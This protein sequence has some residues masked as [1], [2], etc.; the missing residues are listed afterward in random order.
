MLNRTLPVLLASKVLE[1]NGIKTRI[2]GTR[3]YR[4][5]DEN[6]DSIDSYVTYTFK[7]KN[8]SEDLDFNWLAI[9]VA[10]TRFFR[11]NLWK[12]VSATLQLQGENDLGAGTTVYG[13]NELNEVF[14]RY[15]NWYFAEIEAGREPDNPLDKSLMLSGGLS[16]PAN[17]IEEDDIKKEFFRILDVV[18]FQFN[19][20]DK[21]VQ[22]IYDRFQKDNPTWDKNT[23]KDR[24]GDYVIKILSDAY[25]YPE[26]GQYATP[27]KEQDELKAKFENTLEAMDNYFNT[28]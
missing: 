25:S 20:P 28:L 17:S 3:M 14:G 19:K 27:M 4:R 13:G 11:W 9:N 26:K 6:E 2:F 15:K 24:V 23:L 16:N 22:K 8:Y 7:L 12:Y 18:D 10:D 21:A 5:M 1:E